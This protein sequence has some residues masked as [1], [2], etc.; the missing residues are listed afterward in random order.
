MTKVVNDYNWSR[1]VERRVLAESSPSYS[2]IFNDLS[3]RF[4]EKQTFGIGADNFVDPSAG[5]CPL[6][7]RKQPLS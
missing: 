3:V 2:L 7:P 6:Y 4:G 5:E 1:L